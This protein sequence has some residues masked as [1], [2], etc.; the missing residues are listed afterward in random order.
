[1]LPERIDRRPHCLAW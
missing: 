1:M